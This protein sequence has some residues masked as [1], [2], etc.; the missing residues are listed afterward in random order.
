MRFSIKVAWPPGGALILFLCAG[1]PAIA[2]AAPGGV[3]THAKSASVNGP[4][5]WNI[6]RHLD[7]LP[8]IPAGVQTRMFSSAA[9]DGSNHDAK[10]TL[11]KTA[12]GHYLLA[13][14]DGPGE[15]D[16][17]WTTSD[18]GDVTQTGH[19]KVVLDGKTVI[20]APEQDVV[21]GKLGAPF[22]FPLVANA[23]QSS[24]GVYI[25]VPMTFRH[26]MRVTTTHDPVYYHVLYRSFANADGVT[27]FNPDNKA[28][29]VVAMMKAAGSRDPKPKASGQS[30]TSKTF[31]VQPGNS[32]VLAELSGPGRINALVLEMPQLTAADSGNKKSDAISDDILQHA[33]VRISFD[34][35]RTVDAPLGQFFGS[36]LG[37]YTVKAL[38]MGM[39]PGTHTLSSWWPM[40]YRSSARVMLYNGSKHA[41]SSASAQ[42]TSQTR[43]EELQGLGPH[44]HDGYFHATYNR[45]RTT[46][47]RDYP[48][49]HAT[50]QG[51]FVGVS[52]TMRGRVP[53]G[54]LRGYLEGDVHF[55][56]D[57]ARK[58]QIDGTGTEDF[59]QG[60]WYFDKGTFTVPLNGNPAHQQ[61]A[62]TCRHDCTDAYR[63]MLGGVPFSKSIRVGIEHGGVNEVPTLYSSTTFWYARPGATQ[64]TSGT[65]A[66]RND[67]SDSE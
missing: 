12:N 38:M 60:G 25:E 16:A 61:S 42:I 41:I 29:D 33:R 67:S 34:G 23:K 59:Y 46:V 5:G 10:H 9:P 32:M 36:G 24:G 27:T 56:I 52:H 43:K 37:M 54:S 58:P 39:N 7:A 1:V 2:M 11:G 64:N 35:H 22:V 62:Q 14:H 63:L 57:G 65:H 15:V 47:N 26:S 21:D 48:F 18:G 17:I 31:S 53:K 8:Q 51:K 4:V 49:L 28:T 45:Q 55:F 30:A 3:E 19:I 13:K 20:D 40:P 50:G 6:Y 44:G 66:V